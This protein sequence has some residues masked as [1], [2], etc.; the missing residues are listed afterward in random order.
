M[1][2]LS[3]ACRCAILP[4]DLAAL[5]RLTNGGTNMGDQAI[6]HFNRRAYRAGRK[7][8]ATGEAL[9]LAASVWAHKQWRPRQRVWARKMWQSERAYVG[10]LLADYQGFCQGA[11]D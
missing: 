10:Y 4:L 2:A 5:S 8:T 9:L 1:P 7:C 11:L 6:T 3:P